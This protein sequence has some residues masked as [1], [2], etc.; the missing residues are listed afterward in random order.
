MKL[1]DRVKILL[2]LNGALRKVRNVEKLKALWLKA[3]GYK[4]LVGLLGVI[5]YFAA[6][7]FGIEPPSIVLE[8]SY[9]LLGVGLVHKLDK[10]TSII[11]KIIHILG[12]VTKV[13]E[14]KK[15]EEEKK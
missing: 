12:D 13:L 6:K 14:K 4:S 5:G 2:W 9:G 7:Q 3:S 11:G 1:M 10:A 15:D 8:T